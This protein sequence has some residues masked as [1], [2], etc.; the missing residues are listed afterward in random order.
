MRW[1]HP[2]SHV[3]AGSYRAHCTAVG[4]NCARRTSK[5]HPR[6]P[7]LSNNTLC[8]CQKAQNLCPQQGRTSGSICNIWAM[9]Y[10]L[11]QRTMRLSF[12]TLLSTEV[13]CFLHPD[14]Q[15]VGSCW[16]YTAQVIVIKSMLQQQLLKSKYSNKCTDERA[17]YVKLNFYVDYLIF[18]KSFACTSKRRQ[19]TRF[20]PN[21]SSPNLSTKMNSGNLKGK[22]HQ[23]LLKWSWSCAIL[24]SATIPRRLSKSKRDEVYWKAH[25]E[26]S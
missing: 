13:M 25:T 12:Q 26:V 17:S 11:L 4:V 8:D 3:A 7:N 10:S 16:T 22:H 1:A 18:T 6:T 23:I 14:S 15:R 2:D 21:A 9:Q 20:W 19:E 24:E 5:H